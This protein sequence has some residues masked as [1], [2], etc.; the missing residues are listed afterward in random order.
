MRKPHTPPDAIPII[1]PK[2]RGRE[3]VLGVGWSK[4]EE[5]I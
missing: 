4:K 2:E 3:D 5:A 1:A